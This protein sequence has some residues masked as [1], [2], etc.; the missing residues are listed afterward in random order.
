LR[1]F[2]SASRTRWATSIAVFYRGDRGV[3]RCRATVIS[4]ARIA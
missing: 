2:D 4:S 3:V 1:Q